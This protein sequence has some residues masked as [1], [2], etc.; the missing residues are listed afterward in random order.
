MVSTILRTNENHL[1]GLHLK[2]DRNLQLDQLEYCQ[3]KVKS[4]SLGPT[5][6]PAMS[7]CRLHRSSPSQLSHHLQWHSQLGQL[8]ATPLTMAFTWI[9]LPIPRDPGKVGLAP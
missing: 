7:Y 6:K 3:E 8:S 5:Q 2:G 9:V 1:N 4:S